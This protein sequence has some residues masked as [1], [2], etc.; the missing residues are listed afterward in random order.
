MAASATATAGYAFPSQGFSMP[1]QA[2]HMPLAATIAPHQSIIPQGFIAAMP[3]P[4]LPAGFGSPVSYSAPIQSLQNIGAASQP[5]PVGPGQQ[6]QSMAMRQ[7]DFIKPIVHPGHAPRE[8]EE[9]VGVIVTICDGSSYDPLFS[10]VPQLAG[11]GRRVATY[12][13]SPGSLS[14]IFNELSGNPA[15]SRSS[16]LHRN[17]RHLLLDIQTVQPDSV[18]FNWECCSGCNEEHFNERCI[19][20]SLVK[21]LLDRGH[22]VMFSDFSLKALIKDWREELLGPNP[23]VKTGTFSNQFKLRFDPAKLCACPSAQLQKLGELASDGKAELHA[24]SGTIAFSVDWSKADC[25]AYKCDVLTV[26]TELNGKPACPAPGR[27]CQVGSFNGWAGHVLLTYPSGGRILASAGHWVELSRLDVTEAQLL[28]AASSFGAAFQNDIINTMAACTSAQERQ[29]NVQQLS[30][31]M[32][33]Q[34]V[35]CS[36][37]RSMP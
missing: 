24:L 28:N 9:L 26:M 14:H 20:I 15:Q 4:Q 27:G 18:V 6:L 2:L 8:D 3:P 30:S 34:S 19:V 36:Y 25:S 22:M 16:D 23:L 10:Q 29:R 33:Q 32:V 12:A 5:A 13:A 7:A 1:S 35:P 17:L 11:E 37:S 31:L 21:C